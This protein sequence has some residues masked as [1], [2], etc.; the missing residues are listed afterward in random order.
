MSEIKY[1]IRVKA[2]M[3]VTHHADGHSTIR[4]TV[5]RATSNHPEMTR[6]VMIKRLD[7]QCENRSSFVQ[8]TYNTHPIIRRQP[9]GTRATYKLTMVANYTDMPNEYVAPKVVTCQRVGRLT[10]VAL[11]YYKTERAH[12]ARYRRTD[13]LVGILWS[14]MK[15]MFDRAQPNAIVFDQFTSNGYTYDV[16]RARE[17]NGRYLAVDIDHLAI[18]VPYWFATRDELVARASQPIPDHDDN[19]DENH[20]VTYYRPDQAAIVEAVDWILHGKRVDNPCGLMPE[21]AFSKEGELIVF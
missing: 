5:L 10:K 9:R 4:M 18:Q 11:P 17:D 3:N 1:R 12:M 20:C 8:A 6:E 13:R 16:F 15:S 19:P 14:D 2:L 7:G 21:W